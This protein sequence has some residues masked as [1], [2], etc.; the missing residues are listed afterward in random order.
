MGGVKLLLSVGDRLLEPHRF[1]RPTKHAH[2]AT[3][4]KKKAPASYSPELRSDQLRGRHTVASISQF[5]S[6]LPLAVMSTIRPESPDRT[7]NR[8]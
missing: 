3:T 4:P 1:R 5:V 7:Q 2:S 6:C 8:S